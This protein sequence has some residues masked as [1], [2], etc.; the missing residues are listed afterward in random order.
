MFGN[1]NQSLL[2]RRADDAR[3]SVHVTLFTTCDANRYFAGQ[4]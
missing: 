3:R 4:G 1:G 2:I